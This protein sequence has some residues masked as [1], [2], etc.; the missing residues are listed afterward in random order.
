MWKKFNEWYHKVFGS[1]RENARADAVDIKN[2]DVRIRDV[3]YF[4]AKAMFTDIPEMLGIERAVYAGQ[5]PWN[6]R[7]FASELR[8]E[9]DRLYL[10]LR[11]HDRLL[12]FI[13]CSFDLH[14]T[15]A[16]ITNIAVVPDYQNR[17]LGHFLMGV[18]IKKARQLNYKTVSL[19]VRVSNQRAQDLY[20]SLGFEKVGI[21]KGYYFGDHEDAV[22]MVLTLDEPN[23]DAPASEAAR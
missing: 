15:D 21:K 1:P 18:M 19:E 20:E 11:R 5:T 6:E 12:A 3:D 10:V 17:G 23:P 4:L 13:G 7:A 2:H 14:A 22:D 16:H 8:R 9:N